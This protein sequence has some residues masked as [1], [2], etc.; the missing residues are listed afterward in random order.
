MKQTFTTLI[1]LLAVFTLRAQSR[2]PL[3][4]YSGGELKDVIYP[5]EISEISFF[6]ENTE[7]GMRYYQKIISG[8]ETLVYPICLYDSLTFTPPSTHAL[9]N[10]GTVNI[11]TESS[12]RTVVY[13]Y[14][15]QSPSP[16]LRAGKPAVVYFW[17]KRDGE[18]T[19]LLEKLSAEFSERIF[20]YSVDLEEERG[21]DGVLTK[22][23]TPRLGFYCGNGQIHFYAGDW[24][25]H[26]IAAFLDRQLSE[27]VLP[28]ELH[29]CFAKGVSEK[30]GW[31]DVEKRGVPQDYMAC[32]LIT[33]CNMLQW[34]QDQYQASG[35]ALPQGTPDG[36]GNGPYQ[37]AILDKAMECFGDLEKGGG[38]PTGLLWYVEGKS[39][40]ISG[41]SY[42]KKGT[43]G[44]LSSV[45]PQFIDYSS[46]PFTIYDEWEYATDLEQALSVFSEKIMRAFQRGD[47][48]G[49]DIKTHVGL[50]GALHAITIWGVT[51]DEN[52]QVRGLYLTDSDDHQRRL[53]YCKV[54]AVEDP[55]FKTKVIALDIPKN[56]TY[57]KGCEW[58][59]LKAY[60]LSTQSH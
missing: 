24:Q 56:E 34:W 17:K 16:I 19:A 41:Q 6:E 22:E 18:T 23:D 1:C 26:S 10:K 46:R 21:I 14:E 39:T 43:G 8:R 53:V 3:F 7:D 60:H 54:K 59:V 31:W 30:S 9:M 58:E 25:E 5:T 27:T 2:Q 37:M 49:M 47:V 35:H 57:D 28:N 50:G 45:N 51:Y 42:P 11:L 36:E 33:A 15:E 4:F 55:F 13:D 29:K 38:I 12:F 44:Y 48:L 32:W 40:D 20:F 52:R